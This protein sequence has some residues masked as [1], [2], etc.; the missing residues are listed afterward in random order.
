MPE[1][2]EETVFNGYTLSET[3]IVFVVGALVYSLVCNS[4]IWYVI[5]YVGV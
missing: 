1:L 4:V 2:D 3:L 5:P